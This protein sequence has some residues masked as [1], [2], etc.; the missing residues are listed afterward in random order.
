[1]KSKNSIHFYMHDI[2]EGSQILKQKRLLNR[3]NIFIL[4]SINIDANSSE[5]GAHMSADIILKMDL[6]GC[7]GL[8]SVAFTASLS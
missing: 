7:R 4:P 2:T 8:I 3:K 1:M 6:K 5:P